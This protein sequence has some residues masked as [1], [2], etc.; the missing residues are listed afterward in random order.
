MAEID[1]SPVAVFN[2]WSELM[3]KGVPEKFAYS[4]AK[5]VW[6]G[7]LKRRYRKSTRQQ[8]KQSQIDKKMRYMENKVDRLLEE[9]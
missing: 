2:H 1:V 5:G 3:D 6:I 8:I 7:K 4:V 9:E